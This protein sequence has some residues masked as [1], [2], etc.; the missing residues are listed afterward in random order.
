MLRVLAVAAA[1]ASLALPAAAVA[2]SHAGVVSRGVVQ[3]ID[4][5]H[6]VLRTL[7]GSVVTFD[8]TVGTDVRINGGPGSASDIAPGSV[9]EV[10]VDRKGR[11]LVIR[12]LAPPVV[13]DRGVVTAVTKASVTISTSAGNRTFALDRSTRFRVNGGTA[14]RGAVRPGASVT[15]THAIDGPAQVVNVLKRPGA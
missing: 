7:D 5:T 1:L 10:V 2:A 6:L 12:V 15:V 13:T 14:R 3:S 9:A 11:V 8:L 4:P